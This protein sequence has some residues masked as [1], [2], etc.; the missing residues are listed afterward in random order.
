M[1]N[2]A[3]VFIITRRFLELKQKL[4]FYCKRSS[5]SR[6]Q[7]GVGGVG[8][9]WCVKKLKDNGKIRYIGEKKMDD[10]SN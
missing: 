5:L 9:I 8:L 10:S 2:C 3:L 7:G 1:L 6:A 4:S